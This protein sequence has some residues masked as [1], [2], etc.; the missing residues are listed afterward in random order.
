MS[1]LDIFGPLLNPQDLPRSIEAQIK[2]WIDYYLAGVERSHNFDPPHY[3]RPASYL[4]VNLLEGIPGEEMSPCVVIVTR[5]ANNRPERRGRLIDLPMDV[6][7]AVV[8][9]SFE[10]DGAREVAGALGTAIVAIMMHR[11]HIDNR[12]GGKLHVQSWDDVRLDDFSGE[13]ARTRAILRLEFTVLVRGL[14]E[15]GAGPTT[16]DPPVDPYEPPGD[17]PTVATHQATVSKEDA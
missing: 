13:E 15:L 1:D 9:S 8:T 3:Q 4:K 2:K 17:W 16:D 6:G 5:G 12:M 7:L 14:I 11:R 10:A